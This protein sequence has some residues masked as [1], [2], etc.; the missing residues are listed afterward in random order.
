MPDRHGPFRLEPSA[1]ILEEATFLGETGPIQTPPPIAIAVQEARSGSPFSGDPPDPTPTDGPRFLVGLHATGPAGPALGSGAPGARDSLIG[2]SPP[3]AVGSHTDVEIPIWYRNPFPITGDGPTWTPIRPYEDG[4]V[5]EGTTG[6]GSFFEAVSDESSVLDVSATLWHGPSAIA[7]GKEGAITD[8]SGS[9]VG[10]AG[11]LGPGGKP[12]EPLD[13]TGGPPPNDP[14][15][16]SIDGP[17]EATPGEVVTFTAD[18]TDPDGSIASYEW[19]VGGSAVDGD[20]ASLEYAFSEGDTGDRV[21][22]V[23]VTDDDGA[24]ATEAKIVSVT[25]P[26][27]ERLLTELTVE[28]GNAAADAALNS[29]TDT[30]TAL[31]GIPDL[32]ATDYGGAAYF[33]TGSGESWSRDQELNLGNRGFGWR[34]AM[35]EETAVVG[36]TLPGELGRVAVFTKNADGT[37]SEEV[38]LADVTDAFAEFRSVIDVDFA[39]FDRLLPPD[40]E[41]DGTPSETVRTIVV[42]G[43]TDVDVEEDRERVYVF[44]AGPEAGEDDWELA[45]VLKPPT[46]DP[47]GIFVGSV[48]VADN[49]VV[50]GVPEGSGIDENGT[51]YVYGSNAGSDWPYYAE[52]TPDDDRSNFGS[53]VAL[54]EFTEGFTPVPKTAIVGDKGANAAYVFTKERGDPAWT[55]QATITP[56]DDEETVDFGEGVAVDDGTAIVPANTG[57]ETSTVYIFS[58]ESGSEWTRRTF[59]IEADLLPNI[60]IAPV[61][62]D[63]STALVA[64]A[65]K[66]AEDEETIAKGYV[67]ALTGD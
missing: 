10:T 4:T 24:S 60:N 14:P 29:G 32:L 9:P 62:I 55:Q 15:T 53:D 8:E 63:G 3:L 26:G 67:L 65:I 66:D 13:G 35:G 51:A 18:A 7:G 19:E 2:I 22:S 44:E 21:V 41:V 49:D 52:L 31:I 33:F 25:T 54:A 38:Q 50:V 56:D 23:T 16:V 37:W 17:S 61:A 36:S 1:F 57:D 11:L 12:T 42:G 34:T 27:E 64:G 48:A 59:P 28:R 6:S 30:N 5:P 47:P 58:T 43:I 46:D 40:P 39:K 45:D 20:S